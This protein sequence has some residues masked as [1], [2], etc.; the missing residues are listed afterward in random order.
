MASY[1]T[2]PKDEAEPLVAAA[3]K[4]ASPKFK[5]TAAALCLAC[6]VA[7]YQAPS[8]VKTLFFTA[9]GGF[10]PPGPQNPTASW[11][12]QICLKGKNYCLGVP[13]SFVQC[14]KKFR[15]A[16]ARYRYAPLTRWFTRRG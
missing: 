9:Q 14:I 2:I 8:A 16:P 6:A 10:D 3:P 7:G 5:V 4:A 11:D 15:S 1:S 12:V 13:N